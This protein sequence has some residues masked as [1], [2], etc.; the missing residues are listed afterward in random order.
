MSMKNELNELVRKWMEKE[1]NTTVYSAELASTET[2]DPGYSGCETC[3]YGGSDIEVSFYINYRTEENGW[4]LGHEVS[5][6]P[7]TWLAETLLPFE[8][9]LTDSE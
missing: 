3:G 8:E 5:G 7:L 4:V 2:Y 1:M 9:D 6:D